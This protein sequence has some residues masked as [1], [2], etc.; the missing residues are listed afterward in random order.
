MATDVA[1]PNKADAFSIRESGKPGELICRRP[2]PSQ[3]VM[4]WGE[5]GAKRYYNS[6]FEKFGSRIWN[7]GDFVQRSPDT[8]GYAMLGRS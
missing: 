2:F 6:Y 3:P 8:G 4:F 1:D 5:D 7:Q